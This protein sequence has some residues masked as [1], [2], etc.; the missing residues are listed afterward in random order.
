MSLHVALHLYG[1]F[2]LHPM[3]FLALEAQCT[4]FQIAFA[5][6][7]DLLANK[8]RDIDLIWSRIFSLLTAG[9]NISKFLWPS[10]PQAEM[11]GKLLREYLSVPVDSPLKDR[12]IRNDFEHFD[13]RLDT[14]VTQ[15]R[16]NIFDGG[17]GPRA[18]F[19]CSESELFR[20]F[21]P[22]TWQCIYQGRSYPL[23]PVIR[24]VITLREEI[25]RTKYDMVMTRW[26]DA[27]AR[28]KAAEE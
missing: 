21:D 14:F 8:H 23:R 13:E 18:A 17:V 12:S 22:E 26:A 11:R 3:Y 15:E 6:L 2:M 5:E 9:A 24:A 7:E 10:K 16:A 4:A 27:M 28:E 19:P 1:G 25:E 20:H